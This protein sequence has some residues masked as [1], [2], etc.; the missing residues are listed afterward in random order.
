MKANCKYRLVMPRR[1]AIV[2][3]LIGHFQIPHG[4]ELVVA[5]SPYVGSAQCNHKALNAWVGEQLAQIADEPVANVLETLETRLLK[6]LQA[7]FPG[8]EGDVDVP[9]RIAMAA[10][11]TPPRWE[12]VDDGSCASAARLDRRW[13][14]RPME[15]PADFCKRAE[16]QQSWIK[17]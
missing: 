12:L 3:H 5:L 6:R 2:S 14:R 8:A 15:D 16:Q 7:S 1:R 9:S 4:A 10:P 13:Q 11:F 17:E